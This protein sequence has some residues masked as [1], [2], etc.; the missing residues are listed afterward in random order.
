MSTLISLIGEQPIPNLLVHRYIQ[1]SKNILVC[2][3]HTEKI[4][5]RLKNLLPNT[6]IQRLKA[7]E[8]DL[9]ALQAELKTLLQGEQ[10]L[11]F[12]LTG[13]NKLMAIAAYLV[14]QS[15][16]ANCLYL[17]SE[18][19]RSELYRIVAGVTEAPVI[20][21][22]LLDLDAYLRAH[23]PNYRL[24]DIVV[25]AHGQVVDDGKDF[26]RAVA[27]ALSNGGFEVMQNIRPGGVSEQIEIDLA[28]RL[29]NQV[30][31]A[32]V[33]LGDDKSEAPKKG[34]DQLKMAGAREYL[35]TYTAQFLIVGRR[36]PTKIKVLA[37]TRN[38]AVVELP[39]YRAG[40]L[41]LKQVDLLC[42][43][44]KKKLA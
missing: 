39:D 31:I 17:Q 10:G 24:D 12:N 42:E 3:T 32:E 33:K 9:G 8:Y 25:E 41:G 19:K 26:E 7:S 36:L 23:L 13:G 1:P 15:Y 14:A 38:V 21:P 43:A 28:I 35:G 34:L 22:E 16:Q 18:L 27:N 5:A 20:L 37:A 40:R 4:A 2:T 30:G 11:V 44:V 6:S 29:G